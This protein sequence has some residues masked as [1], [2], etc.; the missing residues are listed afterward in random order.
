MI[1]LA[2]PTG[3]TNLRQINDIEWQ[4][5]LSARIDIKGVSVALANLP[6]PTFPIIIAE[7]QRNSRE[8]VRVALDRYNNRDTIDIRAWWQDGEGN[9]RAGRGGLT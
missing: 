2:S 6:A 9:W 8:I 5:D 4:T 3:V 1:L 7:W